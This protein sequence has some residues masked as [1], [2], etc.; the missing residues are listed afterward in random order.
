M[1]TLKTLSSL[2]LISSVTAVIGCSSASKSESAKELAQIGPTVVDVRT[3]P[4]TFDLNQ[5]LQP[6]S[7]SEVIAN[8]KDFNNKVTD[9]KLRFVHIP[10]E[11]SMSQ[12]SPSTWTADLKP[13]QLRILAVNGHTMKYEANVVA[14]DEKGQTS[15]SNNPIEIAVR[16]PD[17][18][19]TG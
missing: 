12:V 4:G 8:V 2:I 9:V 17:I 19:A 1:K 10:L 14:R 7:R 18:N 11:V 15:V 3:N 13:N 5:N 6:V 16:A